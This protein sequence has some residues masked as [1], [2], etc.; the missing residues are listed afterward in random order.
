MKIRVIALAV[1]A[2]GLALLACANEIVV[3]KGGRSME[4]SKPYVIRGSQ[5]VM[6]LKD[7]TVISVSTADIDKAATA[8][9]RK[10]AAGTGKTV[11]VENAASP[12]DAA[13][14]QSAAPKASRKFTD[15]D[16]AHIDYD[17]AAGE[18]KADEKA[19]EGSLT[20]SN[21]DQAA[22]GGNVT[23]KG[24]LRYSGKEPAQN[25]GL[26]VSGKDAAGKTAGTTAADVA[27]GSLENGATTSFTATLPGT[28]TFP[29]VRFQPRWSTPVP[30]EKPAEKKPAAAPPAR[31]PEK[32]A[33][34][35]YR[36][37]PD[38]APPAASAP[39]TPPNDSHTGYIPGA[40]VETPPPPPPP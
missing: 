1:L 33:A 2:S 37:S 5:A 9:A 4:L 30:K 25:I 7:G 26:T 21:W 8:E 6:T 12:A 15:R 10:A 36:G 31:L 34:P 20:V 40:H 32:P 19:G 16:F 38:Y 29:S 35:E 23:V 28:A 24:T 18:P 13:R 14:A 27:A 3:L 39:T 17:E 22:A 11:V